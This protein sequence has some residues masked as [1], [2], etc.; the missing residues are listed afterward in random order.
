MTD[1]LQQIKD[2]FVAAVEAA[3]DST[4]LQQVRVNF[5]GKKGRLTE[6]LKAIGTLEPSKRPAFGDRVNKLRV[7]FEDLLNEKQGLFQILE[8]QAA[9]QKNAID[10]TLPGYAHHR[11]TYHPLTLVEKQILQVFQSLGFSIEE[12][13]DIET[14][15]YNFE[16]LNFPPNHPARD[17]QDTFFV[18]GNRVLRTHTSPVQIRTMEKVKPPVQI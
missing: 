3:K 9:I 1:Q 6:S 16:A 12:G 4:T 17:M 5:M 14:D 11:G 8:E 15:Y 2:D 7:E 13:P 18:N 10:T